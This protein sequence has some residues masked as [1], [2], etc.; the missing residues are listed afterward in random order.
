MKERLL[1]YQPP[2]RIDGEFRDPFDRFEEHEAELLE[3]FQGEWVAIDKD[4]WFAHSQNTEELAQ[5]IEKENRDD[6]FVIGLPD[7]DTPAPF[8]GSLESRFS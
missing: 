8:Y 2:I 3:H 6:V 7:I 5:Q 4:G 1:E